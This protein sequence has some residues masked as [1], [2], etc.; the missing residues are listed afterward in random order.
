MLQNFTKPNKNNITFIFIFIRHFSIFP[1]PT[2][3][4]PTILQVPPISFRIQ[5]SRY[6][7]KY[8]IHQQLL[9]LWKQASGP[10]IINTLLTGPVPSCHREIL[11]LFRFTGS[12]WK[13][14]T[15]K[16][17]IYLH[18]YRYKTTLEAF[19]DEWMRCER[20]GADFSIE[21]MLSFLFFRK[22]LT[23]FY[24]TLRLRFWNRLLKVL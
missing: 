20:T 18:S 22:R 16:R 6:L 13:G 7:S 15:A 3:I 9:L 1:S 23:F 14:S 19:P 8:I 5:I 12:Q 4:T 17:Y 21:I 10:Y 2:T 11:S 24:K